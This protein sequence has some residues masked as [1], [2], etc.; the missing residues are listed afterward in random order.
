MDAVAC[1]TNQ[2]LTAI[3]NDG[4]LLAICLGLQLELGDGMQL[5]T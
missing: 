4:R 1:A 3:K 5:I 2:T